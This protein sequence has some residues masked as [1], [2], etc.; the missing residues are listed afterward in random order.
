MKLKIADTRHLFN[1]PSF[2]YIKKFLRIRKSTNKHTTSDNIEVKRRTADVK[3]QQAPD[4]MS[5]SY[6]EIFD[7]LMPPET[8]KARFL[9]E[10]SETEIDDLKDVISSCHPEKA[11]SPTYVF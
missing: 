1:F 5:E 9:A 7:T 3:K 10:S 4:Q 11:S 2:N 6:H 8:A